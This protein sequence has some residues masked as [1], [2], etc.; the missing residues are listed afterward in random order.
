MSSV[1]H[2]IPPLEFDRLGKR[3]LNPP[4]VYMMKY[5]MSMRRIFIIKCKIYIIIEK[6]NIYIVLYIDKIGGN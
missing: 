3:F 2:D 1:H 5:L 4:Q 6:I